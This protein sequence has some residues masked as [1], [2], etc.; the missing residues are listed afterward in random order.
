MSQ[1]LTAAHLC[2]ADG[3]VVGVP[4]AGARSCAARTSGAHNMH[5]P[6]QR[7]QRPVQRRTLQHRHH[8]A[9]AAPVSSSDVLTAAF[10]IISSLTFDLLCIKD[11]ISK[12][13][14]SWHEHR[15]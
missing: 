12:C 2:V 7:P 6:I 3:R 11:G 14:T 13:L 4:G 15:Q 1:F 9:V 10:E 5:R 8:A